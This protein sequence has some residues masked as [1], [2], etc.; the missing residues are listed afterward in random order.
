MIELCPIQDAGM[1]SAS[2]AWLSCRR[3]FNFLSF[4]LSL[5]QFNCALVNL[6]LLVFFCF[7]LAIACDCCVKELSQ[8]A[9]GHSACSSQGLFDPR[10]AV[11]SFVKCWKIWK[12]QVVSRELGVVCMVVVCKRSG[13]ATKHIKPPLNCVP[14]KMRT[15]S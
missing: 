5:W 1:W 11:L 6:Q 2:G 8:G 14:S 10:C 4:I 9:P 15:C 7:R 12:S 3:K 13:V